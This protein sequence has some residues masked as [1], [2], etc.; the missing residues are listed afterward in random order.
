M[1]PRLAIL[2]GTLTTHVKT[3]D[4]LLTS[5]TR[6][7]RRFGSD[8]FPEQEKER[9]VER[10]RKERVSSK[11]VRF[12]EETMPDN[13]EFAGMWRHSFHRTK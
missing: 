3:Q 9:K 2:V 13:E 12:D 5:V 7:S 11:K 1:S 10:A 4:F 6:L 8:P